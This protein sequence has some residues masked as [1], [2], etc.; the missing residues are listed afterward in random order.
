MYRYDTNFGKMSQ[1]QTNRKVG[2]YNGNMDLG[3]VTGRDRRPRPAQSLTLWE[4]KVKS[5]QLQ[6]EAHIR[7]AGEW[8]GNGAGATCRPLA[9]RR[10]MNKSII[11]CK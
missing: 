1:N 4:N 10:I 9:L 3:R 6:I 7:E 11:F 2:A 8:W 5:K